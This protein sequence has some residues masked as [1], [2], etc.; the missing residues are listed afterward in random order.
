MAY[1]D[2]TLAGA[3]QAFNL[4]LTEQLQLF[5]PVPEQPA[6]DF[7]QETLRRSVPLAIA[8]NS[9]KARS[10]LINFGFNSVCDFERQPQLLPAKL[11]CSLVN[12]QEFVSLQSGMGIE[13]F[14]KNQLWITLRGTSQQNLITLPHRIN[15][16]LHGGRGFLNFFPGVFMQLVYGDLLMQTFS[17]LLNFLKLVANEMNSTLV[18][19]VCPTRN[20]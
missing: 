11:E 9:E 2:F 10:E 13:F 5:A 20:T 3:I 15:F 14:A 18:H 12:W 6:S 17:G 8:S 19:V 4:T 1:S 16:G 7:L